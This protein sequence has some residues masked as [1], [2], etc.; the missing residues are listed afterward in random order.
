[1][2]IGLIA[3]LSAVVV[4]GCATAPYEKNRRALEQVQP[5]GTWESLE[6]ALGPPAI[7][8]DISDSR[9]VA[10]YQTKRNVTSNR[11]VT[12]ALCTSVA[13]ENGQ[14]VQVGQDPTVTWTQAEAAHQRQV[15]IDQRNRQ[16]AEAERLR[17][18][19]E[20]RQKIELLEQKVRPVPASKAGLNLKLYRQLQA[21]DPDNPYYRKKVALYQGKWE[22][23]QQAAQ[24]RAEQAAED[25]KRQ[26]WIDD[27]A[28]RNEQL[29]QYTGSATAQV[30]V[31][32][33]GNGSLYVWVKNTGSQVITTH[34]DHFTLLGD[35]DNVLEAEISGSL[36][37]VVEPGGISHGR[38]AYRPDVMIK[39]LIF[40]N[41]ASGRI[42]K[43]FQ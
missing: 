27:R 39:A 21:L 15:A 40:D 26:A 32:D 33:M 36:D 12:T 14:V 10:Y 29:R 5:G 34:P 23:Q 24:A 8:R 16:G 31:H 37:R 3:L 9:F 20:R 30:A 19:A 13:V 25:Q 2:R 11:A 6:A 7:R 43:P 17:A 18:E 28:A 4:L 35:D 42:T 38:I 22:R 1:M 41:P